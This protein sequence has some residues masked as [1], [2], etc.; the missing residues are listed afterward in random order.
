MA[1]LIL[2]A[3]GLAGAMTVGRPMTRL[4]VDVPR[5][6]AV[7]CQLPTLPELPTLPKLPKLDSEAIRKLPGGGSEC[8]TLSLKR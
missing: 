4:Q 2:L 1:K 7:V 8:A 5:C 6:G 3:L